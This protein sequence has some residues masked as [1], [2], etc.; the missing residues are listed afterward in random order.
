M[1]RLPLLAGLLLSAFFWTRPAA[2]AHTW[3]SAIPTLA[4]VRPTF[5]VN[6]EN[7]H[8]FAVRDHIFQFHTSSVLS[9][10]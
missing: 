1:I 3:P 4:A 6:L 8:L 2:T 9:P 5:A 10:I 7:L